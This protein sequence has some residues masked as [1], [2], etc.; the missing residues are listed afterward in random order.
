MT[1]VHIPFEKRLYAAPVDFG[2]LL[3][4]EDELGAIP[5][6]RSRFCEGVWRVSELVS[7]VHMLLFAAGKTVDYQTLGQ[8]MLHEGMGPYLKITRDFLDALLPK[9]E[10]SCP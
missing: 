9:D 1:T 4:M 8:K 7:V 6:L 2:L 5:A 3:T 10:T